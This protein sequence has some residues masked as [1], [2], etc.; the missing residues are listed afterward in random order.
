MM[1]ETT[2]IALENYYVQKLKDIDDYINKIAGKNDYQ[3]KRMFTIM[4]LDNIEKE[5]MTR[6][7]STDYS[8][9]RKSFRPLIYKLYNKLN[10]CPP[11]RNKQDFERNYNEER[12][13]K[14]EHNPNRADVSKCPA[15]VYTET[16]Y[17]FNE[18]IPITNKNESLNPM[19]DK[20]Y[21]KLRD[22]FI[23]KLESIEKQIND[24]LKQN[25]VNK[26]YRKQKKLII[27]QLDDIEQEIMM[28]DWGI[29]NVIARKD[30]RV[31]MN[32]LYKKLNYCPP[33][34]NKQDFERKEYKDPEQNPN[35][36]D[37]SNCER[38]PEDVNELYNFYVKK[39][40]EINKYI[41]NLQ[42]PNLNRRDKQQRNTIILELDNLEER[43]MKHDWDINY[44]TRLRPLLYYLYNKL[45]YCPPNRPQSHFERKHEEYKNPV[46]N[47]NRD[48]VSKCETEQYED[49]NNMYANILDIQH[50]INLSKKMKQRDDVNVRVYSEMENNIHKN[51]KEVEDSITNKF[52]YKDL[53]PI[54]NGIK[55][56]CDYV[57]NG[58]ITLVG[59]VESS[60]RKIQNEL[61]TIEND[62]NALQNNSTHEYYLKESLVNIIKNLNDVENQVNK[63]QWNEKFSVK[64]SNLND[65]VQEI[66][67]HFIMSVHDVT[68]SIVYANKADAD[69]I[70]S[71]I[72]RYKSRRFSVLEIEYEL[73]DASQVDESLFTTTDYIIFI[74]PNS[75]IPL[76]LCFSQPKIE[77][78]VGFIIRLNDTGKCIVLNKP[79]FNYFDT[80]KFKFENDIDK[81]LKVLFSFNDKTAEI[82]RRTENCRM[83]PW[84]IWINK[85]FQ[86]FYKE[87]EDTH[88]FRQLRKVRV[89]T[90]KQSFFVLLL[91]YM[92]ALYVKIVEDDSEQL[93]DN[94]HNYKLQESVEDDSEKLYDN[95]LKF[96]RSNRRKVKKYDG[97]ML[98]RV[99]KLHEKL[100][101]RKLRREL[102]IKYKKLKKESID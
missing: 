27:A 69:A 80:M 8:S 18:S 15:E 7:W 22:S 46:Q 25:A 21:I 32:K 28:Y 30:L 66:Y 49:E 14:P 55:T 82:K 95:R 42:K 45:K 93:Y 2:I 91:D 101:R 12:Y 43:I 52:W 89:Y 84:Y 13:Q 83:V 16:S 31:S 60:E 24:L 47:N 29:Y 34:R 3:E 59:T 1:N 61:V 19:A 51:I 90:V 38:E 87:R 5:I 64:I 20:T 11:K 102:R 100:K 63:N 48:N 73:I 79:N 75:V 77:Q 97:T 96:G 81:F 9:K 44:R 56:L 6:D 41:D 62:I 53:I 67:D 37:L 99:H 50:Q 86:R 17:N 35:R 78:M 4:K 88:A 92:S 70:K 65:K 10:Y 76:K 33:R 68:I 74:F 94:R 57:F 39:L 71:K 85:D 40:K 98:R 54:I 58:R 23:K 36:E 26:N 72:S